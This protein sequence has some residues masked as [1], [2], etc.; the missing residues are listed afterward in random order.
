M[1][2]FVLP[3]CVLL[4]FASCSK[5]NGGS[6]DQEIQNPVGLKATILSSG[7]AFPWEIVYGPDQQIWFTQRGGKISKLNLETKT[8][9]LLFTVPDVT[10]VGEGGLLG[11]VLHPAFQANPY[12]YIVYDYMQNSVYKEKVVR[13]TYSGSTLTSPL[14]LIDQIPANSN[15]NGSRLMISSDLKLYITTGD[16]GTAANAQNL[17]SVS[18]KI[19]RLNL[20]G[21]IPSDNPYPGNP[22]WSFGHRNPQG[23]V[24]VNNVLYESEHGPDNDDEVN[25]IQKGRNYGW[26]N[27]EGLCDKT[28]EATFCAANNIVEPLAIWTPTIA[29]SGMTY[30]G[31]DYIPQWKNSLLMVSLKGTK[32][33]QLELDGSGLV[34]SK[35]EFYVNAFGRLRAIC[36]SP[37]GKIYMATSNGSDDK[38]IEISRQ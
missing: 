30:Y 22:V 12:V 31:S 29:P 8:V 17:N 37:E 19:L 27:V 4:F 35:N 2:R 23:L 38:I 25:L 26:P 3:L 7:L 9:T 24:Q 34:K 21:T 10:S 5:N 36:Q 15:H 20:D 33:M 1:K 16:A 13:Y 11:M 32:L 14:T 18:G 6:G 28:A